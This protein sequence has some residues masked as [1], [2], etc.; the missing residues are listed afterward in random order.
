MS[1]SEGAGQPSN[2]TSPVLPGLFIHVEAIAEDEK[3]RLLRLNGCL[4]AH[5]AGGLSAQIDSYTRRGDIRLIFDLT[6]V[7][8]LSSTGIDCFAKALKAVK[9][10]GGEIVLVGLHER[11]LGVLRMY[12][13]EKA[14]HM[15]NSIADAITYLSPKRIISSHVFPLY[16]KCPVCTS[17][18]KLK[19]PMRFRCS[20]CRT[21]MT[22][23]SAGSV[24]IYRRLI[25]T[26]RATSDTE[27]SQQLKESLKQG[28]PL[29]TQPIVDTLPLVQ[30][31]GQPELV[32]HLERGGAHHTHCI[33][34][35][36]PPSL[37][38]IPRPDTRMPPVFRRHFKQILRLAFYDVEEKRHL[39]PWQFPKRIPRRADVHKAIHFFRQTQ[40]QASGYTIHCWQG[41]SRSTAF[42]LGF[43][44][45]LTN[46]ED[47]AKRLLQQIRPEA[48]P[49]QRIVE[50]FDDELGCNL[51]VVNAQIRNERIE[52]WKKE[53][54]LTP[55]SLLEELPASQDD[56]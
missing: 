46:S 28:R 21:I 48:G 47:E 11:V 55:D 23:D 32:Q 6:Q 13:F 54:D 45:M 38:C 7:F 24:V 2:D 43:L 27:T 34:I 51:S 18:L 56:E 22:V 15:S 36:N 4:D 39:R 52:R 50:W 31:F 53:L 49:H 41:I 42:A 25:E 37:F 35:G 16:T 10:R 20:I 19:K 12:G 17:W 1:K 3:C 29:S 5:T 30:V 26:V 44:Y 9:P 40:G 14:F 8:Y 33:S